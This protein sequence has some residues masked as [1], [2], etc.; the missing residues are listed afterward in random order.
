M[1]KVLSIVLCLAMVA[2]L[3]TGTFAMTASAAPITDAAG[4]VIDDFNDTTATTG[5][6]KNG[7]TYVDG[8]IEIDMATASQNI[9]YYELDQ[10]ELSN[11]D[12]ATRYNIVV[13]AKATSDFNGRLYAHFKGNQNGETVQA[14]TVYYQGDFRIGSTSDAYMG[15]ADTY[16]EYVSSYPIPVYGSTAGIEFNTRG[17]ATGT[18]WIEKIALVPVTE[19][20]GGYVSCLGYDESIGKTVYAAYADEGYKITSISYTAGAYSNS[21]DGT[22]KAYTAN[23]LMAD[24][25]KKTSK[26]QM[27]FTVE[28][29][30][31]IMGQYG[32]INVAFS[33]DIPP[34]QSANDSY[35]FADY[36][37]TEAGYKTVS[38][39]DNISYELDLAKLDAN[40]KYRIRMTANTV[41]DDEATAVTAW[42]YSNVIVDGVYGKRG[43]DNGEIRITT[44][45]ATFTA[46]ASQYVSLDTL[47][48]YGNK[49]V[50]QVCPRNISGG[51]LN[52]EKLE[53]IPATDTTGNNGYVC[54]TGY[55]SDRAKTIYTAYAN[56]GYKVA[57]IAAKV[58]VRSSTSGKDY[59]FQ[60]CTIEIINE[61]SA[62]EIEFVVHTDQTGDAGVTTTKII[63]GAGF[64]EAAFAEDVK[65][66]L[67][68]NESYTVYSADDGVAIG[69]GV[70]DETET[71]DGEGYSLR[72]DDASMKSQLQTVYETDEEGNVVTDESGNKVV[73]YTWTQYYDDVDIKLDA[74]DIAHFDANNRYYVR[75]GVKS[76]ADWDG[77]VYINPWVTF[78]GSEKQLPRAHYYGDMY[79]VGNVQNKVTACP[80]EEWSIFQS[81]TT[82]PVFGTSV[83]LQFCIR[84]KAD[85]GEESIWID[86]IELVPANDNSL[87]HG[88]VVTETDLNTG[89]MVFKAVADEGYELD[90]MSIT[91]YIYGKSADCADYPVNNYDKYPLALTAVAHPDVENITF[92]VDWSEIAA[93]TGSAYIICDN[94]SKAFVRATFKKAE[95]TLAGD[96]N[97]DGIVDVKDLIRTKRYLA[98]AKYE[99]NIMNV[100]TESDKEVNTVDLA[101][102]RKQLLGF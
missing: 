59:S 8:A 64:I 47:S 91:P 16:T 27:T 68:P 24:I 21:D 38:N 6:T 65:P 84:S 63:Y 86:Y 7:V 52:I 49:V 94:A 76:T 62:S 69:T 100:D 20:K 53:L 17:D 55:D 37:T 13:T 77:Q 33:E 15:L 31:L 89:K 46:E 29:K 34:V 30:G 71:M 19:I 78:D 50:L 56:E 51:T 88:Y 67:S 74:G 39:S 32:Y 44:N 12:Y 99:I 54:V 14:N 92:S 87:A 75:I 43:W 18:L 96:A 10:N 23:S 58:Q 98:G 85:T 36:T 28:N 9:V 73:D 1:K 102:L 79:L 82:I 5:W 57:N 35:V 61:V 70:L 48:I 60:Y 81:E 72:F 3:F 11:L 22:L 41:R 45:P 25:V 83:K 2:T 97:A 90:T 95:Q 4:Y 101:A 80:D 66:M 26:R 93:N 42:V 40:T